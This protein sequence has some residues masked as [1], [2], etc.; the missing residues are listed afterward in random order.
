MTL[1]SRTPANAAGWNA[2]P[3]TVT[4]ACADALS[5]AAAATVTTTLTADGADQTAA[6]TCRDAAGN[7]ATDAVTGVD[8]DRTAPTVTWTGV[9]PSYRLLDT[10]AVTCAAAD[11]LS[12]VATTTCAPVTRLAWTLGPGDT[13]LTA[14]ATDRAGTPQSASA[15]VRVTVTHG[16]LCE[17]T[18]RFLESSSAGGAG[19][20]ARDLCG[21]LSL[22]G[23][24]PN[25]DLR[26]SLLAAYV[27]QVQ[28]QTP[29]LLTAA[30]AATLVRFAAAL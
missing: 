3:V 29:R 20:V 30:Q 9:A 7:T 5:G 21:K 26:R 14:A 2:G 27:K 24:T 18:R 28:A 8:I 15:T 25:A 22:A 17:L 13:V 4:W 12:G 6:G 19:A 23:T 11:A 16:D 10:V 1:V